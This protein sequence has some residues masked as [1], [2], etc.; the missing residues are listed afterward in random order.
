MRKRAYISCPMTKGNR[1]FNQYQ[2]NEAHRML[3]QAGYAVMNPAMT[4]VLPFAWDGSVS[5][6]EWL[7]SD[8]AWIAVCDFVVRLPGE[9]VGAD[10]ETAF[11]ESLGIP[12]VRVEWLA[13][14]LYI[15]KHFIGAAV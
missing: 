14:L 1:N 11:A 6:A 7:D 9:S 10:E 4:G 5:H 2:A 15:V 3:L 8:K 13:D 12:V